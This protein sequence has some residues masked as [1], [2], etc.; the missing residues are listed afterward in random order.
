MSRPP[1]APAPGVAPGVAAE[2]LRF[3]LSQDLAPAAD[4]PAAPADAWLPGQDAAVDTVRRLVRGGRSFVVTGLSGPHR[5]QR[6]A[7]LLGRLVEAPTER[8][9]LVYVARP[10]APER[11]AL[12]ALPS[13]SA[14]AFRR[15]L[16][17]L[18]PA[19]DAAWPTLD[20]GGIHDADDAAWRRALARPFAPLRDAFPAAAG[21]LDALCAAVVARDDLFRPGA[22]LRRR[23]DDGDPDARALLRCLDVGLFL[24]D[25]GGPAVCIA[26]PARADLL[27]GGLAAGDGPGHLRLRPGL[28]HRAHG[29][30]LVVD[31]DDLDDASLAALLSLLRTGALAAP[32]VGAQPSLLLP[33]PVPVDLRVALIAGSAAAVTRWKDHGELRPLVS[34]P[35]QLAPHQP[36][37]AA[38]VAAWWRWLGPDGLTPDGAL[39]MVEAL[40]REGGRGGRVPCSY[41]GAR[42]LL[43]DARSVA[44]GPVDRAA[45]AAAQ[46]LRRRERNGAGDRVVDAIEA[47]FVRV[48]TQGAVVGQVN[49]LAVYRGSG[50]AFAR[51]IRITATAGVGRG[52]LVDVERDVGL[53]GTSFKKGVRLFAGLLRSRFSR[54]RTLSVQASIAVEQHYGQIDG[55][56]ASL[57]GAC[58]LVS[59]LAG[60]PL[61]QAVAVTGSVDQHGRVN[62]VGS[63]TRK[64]EGYF[65]VCRRAG[66]DGRQGVV[67]PRVNVADLCLRDDVV[68]A[69]A[70]GRFHIWPV[71]DLEGALALLT[72]LPVGDPAADKWPADTVY[73][74]VDA[75]LAL[76]ERA[77]RRAAKGD[78]AT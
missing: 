73:G 48:E 5:R 53:S 1:A 74:K 34:S 37:S 24:A 46:A 25:D 44:D 75:T 58:A 63:V 28:V 29:G 39:A 35:V 16:H 71:D 13:G 17:E 43:D 11:P 55:D 31:L 6:L 72:D 38:L 61:S 76:F 27:L 22:G 40:V 51:P 57:A 14:P 32:P 52:A 36:V 18:G 4:A 56:S 26:D 70:A 78:N 8:R 23:A 41:D 64:V 12:L 68:D 69:I 20:E 65:E 77:N 42:S 19:L 60:V 33:D 21:W 50:F 2:F 54:Q 10:T 66:L 9:D 47:G 45:V 49:G 67:V 7:D 59:A 62:S 15:A 3:R 30:W